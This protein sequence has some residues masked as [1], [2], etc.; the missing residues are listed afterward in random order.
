MNITAIY[1]GTFDPIT[2]GHIDLV[3]RAARLFSRVIVAVAA[4]PAKTPAFS[5]DERVQLARSALGE[6]KNVEVCGFDVL[7]ADFAE[8]RGVRVILR[9]LRAVSD[10]EHEFQ[11]AGMNR[12]LAPEIETLFLTPAEQYTYISSSLVREIAKYGGDVSE[13]VPAVVQAALLAKRRYT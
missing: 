7:L 8:K 13:F 10:F 12:R 5:L 3:A 4:N 9:G 11:L 6:I 2:N 1:P